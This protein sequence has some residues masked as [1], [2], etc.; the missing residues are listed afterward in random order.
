MEGAPLAQRFV[1]GAGYFRALGI[2]LR[3][4]RVFSAADGPEAP[5]VAVISESAARRYWPGEDPVGTRIRLGAAGTDQERTEVVGVV[6][7]VLQ[8]DESRPWVPQLYLP[9]A[10]HPRRGMVLLLGTSAD[11]QALAEPLRRTVW[12]LDPDQPVG[13]AQTLARRWRDQS[14][15]ALAIILLFVL[16]AA[17]A[18]ALAVAGV[19]AVMAYA[20]SRRTREF[21]IRMAL[22]AETRQVVGMVLR[23]GAGVAAA[24]VAVGL[25]AAAVM[26]RLL[27][28]MLFRVSPTEPTA[29]L[30]STGLLILV[31][32]LASLAPTLRAAHTDLMITLRED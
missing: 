17:A 11:P 19:Y 16:F 25:V 3:S 9:F 15:T 31:A 4:G 30:D 32:V 21:G 26:A 8:N 2:P 20:V 28:G 10:Q 29:F 23:Q 13:A 27:Q 24:G 7:D 5:P 14:A 6:A 1:V 22:G 12:S 18:L